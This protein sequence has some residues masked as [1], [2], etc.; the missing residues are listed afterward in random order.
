MNPSAPSAVFLSDDEL[1][2]VFKS[3]GDIKEPVI[4]IA[5]DVEASGGDMLKNA[6]VELGAVAYAAADTGER[7]ILGSFET[8]LSIPKDR[9]WEEDCVKEFWLNPEN[10]LKEKKE[11]I[12]ACT[13]ESETAMRAFVDFVDTVRAKLAGG[14]R[15]R[16][17]FVTDNA[18]FDG[19]WV[20]LY[21][22]MFANHSPLHTFFDS[23]YA[24]L[25]D[26]NAFARGV[27][28]ATPD[29]EFAA[30]GSF[31]ATGAARKSLSIPDS[32]KPTTAH[33]HRS[34]NDARHIAE[35]YL[36]LL[37]ALH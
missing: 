14:N 9:E 10:N 28:S 13:V 12:D 19:A 25:I 26:T 16:V 31:S 20:S 27:S 6:E 5:F 22:A 18:A 37:D 34:V 33:D 35:E 1:D 11:Q 32:V 3:L 8:L 30:G 23:R 4:I 36:I 24:P 7:R 21:L 29:A 2:A 15:R 17:R